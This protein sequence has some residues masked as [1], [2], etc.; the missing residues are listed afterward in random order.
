M[1][2]EKQRPTK[3][4]SAIPPLR[5]QLYSRGPTR[6]RHGPE[7]V[8]GGT[9]APAANRGRQSRPVAPASQSGFNQSEGKWRRALAGVF[10]RG[11][12]GGG[13]GGVKAGGPRKWGER[14]TC[15]GPRAGLPMTEQRETAR[16]NGSGVRGSPVN[17]NPVRGDV[18]Q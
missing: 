18:S 6:L 4:Q 17:W 11:W 8:G 5:H 15:G 7:S 12:K 10:P 2:V 14:V 1:A 13:R 16:A 3:M 9:V